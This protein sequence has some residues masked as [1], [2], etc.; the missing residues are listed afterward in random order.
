MFDIESTKI[1]ALQTHESVDSF[2]TW[3]TW[4][5]ET[6]I[7]NFTKAGSLPYL[8]KAVDGLKTLTTDKEMKSELAIF[9][10]QFTG[11]V[12]A[13]EKGIG[14][15]PLQS[16]RKEKI[17]EI[18]VQNAPPTVDGVAK[19]IMILRF[20]NSM[21]TYGI[22]PQCTVNGEFERQGV[23]TI[24]Y[25]IKGSRQYILINYLDFKNF[26]GLNE[27]ATMDMEEV[28]RSSKIVQQLKIMLYV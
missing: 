12:Q 3:R 8:I 10:V 15:Q 11:S 17:R 2:D 20:L 13:K 16:S 6:A 24:R 14:Q 28:R 27:T 5:G 21:S 1:V 25:Q 18:M 26:M 19:D 23:P 7:T 4:D 9:Q 22:M